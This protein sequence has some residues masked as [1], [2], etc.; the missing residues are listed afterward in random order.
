MQDRRSRTWRLTKKCKNQSDTSKYW[1]LFTNVTLRSTVLLCWA[2][3]YTHIGRRFDVQGC[4]GNSKHFLKVSCCY[5]GSFFLRSV[6]RFFC[7]LSYSAASNAI[8]CVCYTIVSHISDSF[9]LFSLACSALLRALCSLAPGYYWNSTN[10]SLH[11][12]N[13]FCIVFNFH[14]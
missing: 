12:R 6:S 3:T 2:C 1:Q 14:S 11:S 13:V 10:F 8:N 7:L 4:S 9:R 5:L